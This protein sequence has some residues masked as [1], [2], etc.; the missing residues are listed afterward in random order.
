MLEIRPTRAK[1][2]LAAV[3]LVRPPVP[4]HREGL[5]AFPA[6]EGLHAVL[7]L[8]VSLESS[9]VLQGFCPG[10]VDVVLAPEG[11]TVAREFEHGHGLCPLERIR[12]FSVF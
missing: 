5:A 11:A 8:V 1:P 4:S 6:L 3:L 2:H 10:V 9:E 7:P 12:P